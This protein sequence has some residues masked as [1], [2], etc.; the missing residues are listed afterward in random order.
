MGKIDKERTEN[1]NFTKEYFL[2]KSSMRKTYVG[3]L[4]FLVTKLTAEGININ[5]GALTVGVAKR[6]RQLEKELLAVTKLT[7]T[8]GYTQGQ[9]KQL[10]DLYAGM[11]LDEAKLFISGTN[12][13]N[14]ATGIPSPNYSAA[15]TKT[16]KSVAEERIKDRGLSVAKAIELLPKSKLADKQLKALIADTYGDILLATQNTEPA[17]KKIVRETVRDVAQF[18]ALT[19][20]A[21]SVQ[22]EELAE[23]LSVKGLTK[24][25]VKE[26]FVGITDKAGRRWDLGTYSNMVMKTKVNQAYIQGV[27]YEAE[28]LGFDLAVISAHGAKDACRR[29]E[30]V[31]VSLNGNTKGY[32][33]L[34]DAKSTGEIFH[35]NCEHSVHSI[36]NVDSL[37]P[38]DQKENESKLSDLGDYKKRSKASK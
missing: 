27:S 12:P 8:K 9:A 20:E 6:V 37:H 33:T 13:T 29:W 21:Y 23:R 3:L 31:V 38:D 17:I 36:R 5:Q 26:G 7:I 24:R 4:D 25:I 22:A 14:M 34:A 11:T 16:I 32:P 30:G 15:S 28:E 2:L 19:G 1:N 35:P 10:Q 18:N